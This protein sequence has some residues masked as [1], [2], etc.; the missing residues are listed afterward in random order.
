MFGKRPDGRVIKTLAPMEK[1]IPYIMKERHDSMTMYEDNFD[2]APLDAYIR[3]KR[4]QGIKVTYMHILIAAA[5]RMIALRPAL[6]RFVMRGRIYARNKIWM[7]FTL[8]HSLRDEDDVEST[9]KVCFDG[10]ETI[11]EV[12]EK[13][14]KVI[15]SETT[16]WK[17]AKDSGN[18]A[19]KMIHLLDHLPGF[20]F[21]W[22]VNL[23]MWMDKHNIMPKAIVELSPFHT[24]FFL[25]NLKSLGINHVFHHVY[26]FGTT[27]LFLAMGKEQTVPVFNG[28]EVVK[29]KQMPFGLVSD[30]RFCDGLYFS[31]SIRQ[32]RKLMKNP[33]LLEEPLEKKLEDIP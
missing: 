24:S 5:V 11:F 32:M 29:R 13:I 12:I 26:D 30:E 3:E 27:G 17:S 2:C 8:H 10:T 22:A 9:I 1:I 7:S 19:D 4:E 23:L 33:A 18:S 21:R 16:E 6:N 14:N 31:R 15:E 25:T 28:D 20:V